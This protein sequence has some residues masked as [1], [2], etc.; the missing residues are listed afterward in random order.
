MKVESDTVG[1]SSLEVIT[2]REHPFFVKE[3][4]KEMVSHL[5]SD[6]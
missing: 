5:F 2:D 1:Q 3:K 6:F 4:G